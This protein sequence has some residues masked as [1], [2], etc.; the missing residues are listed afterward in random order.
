MPLSRIIA[1][2]V[3]AFL[4][5]VVGFPRCMRTTPA[6]NFDRADAVFRG[7]VTNI[8]FHWFS[9][10][11]PVTLA[12]AESWKGVDSNQVIVYATPEDPEGYHFQSGETYVVYAQR[13]DGALYVGMCSPTFAL[14]NAATQLNDLSGK[15]LI[16]ITKTVSNGRPNIVAIT[17]V[18]VLLLLA[19]GYTVRRVIKRAA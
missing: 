13:S 6:E 2:F 4:T 9:R 1:V 19:V 12:V 11:E 18:T 7:R 3:I 15:T 8:G 17:G 16:P 5:C 10:Y 14:A